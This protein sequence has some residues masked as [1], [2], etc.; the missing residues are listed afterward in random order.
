[1]IVLD[2]NVL[3]EAML[4]EPAGP[5]ERWMRAQP[6]TD[7]FTTAVCEAEIRRGIALMPA[8]RRRVALEQSLARIFAELL[9]GRILAFD[10]AAAEAFAEIAAGRQQLGRPIGPFDAQIAAIA[11]IH[12]AAVA[13]RDTDDFANCGIKVINPW[14]T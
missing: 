14:E 10:S 3:S 2:T 8:G 4:V 6:L 7:L 1:M 12:K 11:L 13:T 9:S 5:L